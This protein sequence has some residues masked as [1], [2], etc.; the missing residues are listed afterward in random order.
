MENGEGVPRTGNT[1]I[2]FDK[3]DTV[4]N[5]EIS[6]L[7]LESGGEGGLYRSIFRNSFRFLSLYP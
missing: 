2:A 1:R 7:F 4:S 3:S 5:N 6:L